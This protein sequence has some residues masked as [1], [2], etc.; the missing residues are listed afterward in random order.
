LRDVLQKIVGHLTDL[1]ASIDD[2]KIS[3]D[4]KFKKLKDISALQND[5]QHLVALGKDQVD[6]CVGENDIKVQLQN[7]YNSMLAS[8]AKLSTY[9]ELYSQPSDEKARNRTAQDIVDEILNMIQATI[10]LLRDA[11]RF[12]IY[13]FDTIASA[14]GEAA[15][16]VYA[17]KT[18]EDLSD[19][20]HRLAL[21]SVQL[22]RG[23]AQR[24][25]AL[26][27]RN[28]AK[29]L[30]DASGVLQTYT[31]PLIVSARGA[32][33]GSPKDEGVL[34][35]FISA[36]K[37]ISDTLRVSPE[38]SVN[39]EVSY[40]DDELKLKLANLATAVR[41]GDRVGVAG[42]CKSVQAEVEKQAKKAPLEAA[43]K[44]RDAA[45]QVAVRAKETLAVRLSTQDPTSPEFSKADKHF[46]ASIEAL[47]EACSAFPVSTVPRTTTM[48]LLQAAQM[49]SRKFDTLLQK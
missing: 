20:A 6:I 17:S 22:A 4:D 26:E 42:G 35:T 37:V 49:L 43:Q 18:A 33:Q 32:L 39:F 31:G 9:F 48:S 44:A 24:A 15:K 25:D 45:D 30:T 14:V 13:S 23:V 5:L 41:A 10:F 16:G 28:A 19:A 11:D 40:I 27:D 34:A 38:F 8:Q 47:R 46:H 1:H 21:L 36:I 2:N 7:G 12:T 3:V 29:L